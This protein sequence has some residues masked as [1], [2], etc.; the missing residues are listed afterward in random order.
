MN[1]FHLLEHTADIGIEALTDTREGLAEQS[2]LGLRFLLFSDAIAETVQTEEIT[3]A[4][5]SCE[6]TLVNW[7]NELLFL[8]ADKG[9]VP[10]QIDITH[11]AENRITARINGE[12]ITSGRHQ[13]LREIKAVTHHLASIG[14]D[15]KQWRSTVYL[16]L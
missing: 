12:P 14:H 10:A 9:L 4:G 5:S 15:G 8:M 6:E 7:L 11:F 3:S 16:D 1:R 2:G 13:M